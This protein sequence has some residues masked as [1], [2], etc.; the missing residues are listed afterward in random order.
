MNENNVRDN[1][2]FRWDIALLD[3]GYTLVLNFFF[4]CYEATW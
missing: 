1:F 3:S 4:D 2:S